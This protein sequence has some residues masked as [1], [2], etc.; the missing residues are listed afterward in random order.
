MEKD[1]FINA[2]QMVEFDGAANVPTVLFYGRSRP[3][4]IGSSALSEAAPQDLNEDFKLD[5][6][7][8]DHT[9]KKRRTP[10]FTATGIPKS[11]ADLTADFLHEV[12]F[13]ILIQLLGGCF[14]KS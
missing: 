2:V 5:L 4:L 3:V 13:E 11:A 12:D 6:G 14:C 8:I 10:F 7:E 1:F 9:S